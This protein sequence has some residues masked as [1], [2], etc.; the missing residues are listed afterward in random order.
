LH[1][2]GNSYLKKAFLHNTS[3]AFTAASVVISRAIERA[4][5]GIVRN[6]NMVLTGF[7]P[8]YTPTGHSS[9]VDAPPW[10]YAGQILSLAFDVER[11]TAQ[12]LLPE[13]F[14]TATE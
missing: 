11:D 4:F 14:G 13:K 9:L 12:T 5:I 8:P 3:Q 1:Y 2:V 7:T 6:D 10:H